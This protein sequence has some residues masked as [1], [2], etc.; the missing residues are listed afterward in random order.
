MMFGVA[1]MAWAVVSVM[2]GLLGDRQPRVLGGFSGD[3]LEAVRELGKPVL[4]V[5]ACCRSCSLS[6]LAK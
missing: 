6:G 2:G 1:G 3:A 4:V 5:D